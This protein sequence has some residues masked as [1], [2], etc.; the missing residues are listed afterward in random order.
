[1]TWSCEYCTGSGEPL[2]EVR[3][4]EATATML[5]CSD[6]GSCQVDEPIDEAVLHAF[7]EEAYFGV[8][9]IA[10]K[11]LGRRLAIDYLGKLE[12]HMSLF[13]PTGE[14]LEIGAGYGYFARSFAASS[15]RTIDVVEPNQAC[16]KELA[17]LRSI[18]IVGDSFQHL[19]GGSYLNVFAFHVIEHI[20]RTAPFLEH[21][22]KLT[23]PGAH[24]ALITPNARAARFQAWGT[25]WLWARPDQHLQFLSPDIPD[26]FFEERGFEVVVRQEL[27]A[28]SVAFPSSVLLRLEDWK[29]RL[30]SRIR[31][32]S[33]SRLALS[34]ARRGVRYL[35]DRFTP[36][37]PRPNLLALERSVERVLRTGPPD[38]AL[39]ILR[40][41]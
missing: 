31:D 13:A 17:S 22:T 3:I 5:R 18:A 32:G 38:E 20:S 16:R 19:D 34:A 41:A 15:G 7:Y 1:M 40:R 4:G 11:E 29:A 24:V 33:R 35:K 26:R 39:W 30:D 12:P 36:M 6:C 28:G 2:Y 8:N 25:R 27:A 21:L 9:E 10:E 14:T 23:E 37:F